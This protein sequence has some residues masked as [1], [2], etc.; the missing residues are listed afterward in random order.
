MLDFAATRDEERIGAALD[1]WAQALEV[2][3]EKDESRAEQA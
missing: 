3:S 1:A 2:F